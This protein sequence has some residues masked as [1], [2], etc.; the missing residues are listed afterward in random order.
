MIVISAAFLALVAICPSMVDA[1]PAIEIFADKSNY[2]A[3]DTIELSLSAANSEEGLFVDVYVGLL[4]PGGGIMTCGPGGL[5]GAMTPWLA[6]AYLPSGFAFGPEPLFWFDVPAGVEGEF[7]FGAGLAVPGTGNFLS[8]LSFAP[9]EIG[10]GSSGELDFYVNG[11]TGSDLG[12]GSLEAP[13]KTIAHALA[14]VDGSET[15]PVAIHI[16]AGTYAASTNGETFPLDMESWIS[17]MGEDRDATILDAEEEAYHVIR[18]NDVNNV[19]IDGLTITGGIA[20]GPDPDCRG[21][22]IYCKN[23]PDMIISNNAFTN[24]SGTFGAGLYVAWCLPTIENNDFMYNSADFGSGVCCDDSSAIIRHNTFENNAANYYGVAIYLGTSSPSIFNNL[25]LYNSGTAIYNGYHSYAKIVNNTIVANSSTMGGG[26]I[27][28]YQGNPT[29]K[30]CIFWGNDDDLFD[31]S[32]TFCCLEDFDDGDG[33][34]HVFPEF[35]T[36]PLGGYYLNLSSACLNAGSRSSE[37]AGLSDRT[38][39]TDGTPDTDEVDMG[40]HYPIP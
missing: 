16:A 3:G 38:T 8:E 40:F 36:G 17:L 13:F 27:Y 31:C 22:G 29:I 1:E 37:E 18:C 9:F 35:D 19:T 12:D 6:N 2:E 25:I 23:C 26:G 39:Q 14:S 7:Q 15:A 30:D 11:G 34:L 33:N 21:S 20:D 5:S 10:G 4:M 24:N 28:N 32:A